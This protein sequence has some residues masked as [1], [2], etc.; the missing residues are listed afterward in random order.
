MSGD[1][2]DL[3][4]R[5]KA[6]LCAAKMAIDDSPGDAKDAVAAIQARAVLSL[7]RD[8]GEQGGLE[9]EVAADITTMA[10]S[11][12]WGGTHLQDILDALVKPAR[13]PPEPKPGRGKVRRDNQLMM[14]TLLGYFTN[15]E[16]NVLLATSV[17]AE[18][19]M[20]QVYQRMLQLNLRN[21]SEECLHKLGAWAILMEFGPEMAW[22]TPIAQRVEAVEKIKRRFRALRKSTT[23][24]KDA[25]YP[26]PWKACRT[27]SSWNT[28]AFTT[29]LSGQRHLCHP[30]FASLMYNVWQQRGTFAVAW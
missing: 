25:A 7:V 9:D 17:P 16:W 8:I 13:G 24:P 4:R 23:E 15:A 21:P 2:K 18:V 5:L 29:L 11:V 26:L 28:R 19:R 14:P 30:A 20:E 6:R 27:T 22:S 3:V 1:G 10:S 12:P